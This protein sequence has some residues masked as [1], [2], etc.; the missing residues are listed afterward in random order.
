M[1]YCLTATRDVQSST[2]PQLRSGHQVIISANP[3]VGGQLFHPAMSAVREGAVY[4]YDQRV[5][6]NTST[7][8][9]V[10]F[11]DTIPVPGCRCAVIFLL[12]VSQA[13]VTLCQPL[14]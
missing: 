1:Y 10:L 8:R 14:M 2:I 6:K 7:V 4:G 9:K 12:K 5:N 13:R 3:D 11:F